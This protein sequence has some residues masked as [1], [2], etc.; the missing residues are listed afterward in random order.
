MSVKH[1]W[2]VLRL[3]INMNKIYLDFA[4]TTPVENRVLKEMNPY[5]AEKF[6][7]PNS[8]HSFGREAR[9]GVDLAREKIANH[10]NCLTTEIVFTSGATEANNLALKGAV[11]ATL[12]TLKNDQ[13]V[14]IIISN[15]EHHCILDTAEFLTKQGVEVIYA[16]V[17]KEG[18]LK[19]ETLEALINENTILVSVMYANNEIGTIQPIAEI[20]KIIK[21]VREKRK[22]SLPIYFHT[23][24]V[25]A[26]NYLDCDTEKLGVDLLSIS[27]HKIYGPK[28]VGALYK[29]SNVVILPQ[30]HGG[31]Q[32]KGLRSGTENVAGIVGFG[33]AVELVSQESEANKRIAE[34]RDYFLNNLLEKIP[35]IFLNGS[36]KERLP[37]NINITVLGVEGEAILLH[38]DEFGIAA[39]TGSACTSASLDPSHVILSLGLPAEAAHGSLRFSLGRTTTKKEIEFVLEKLPSII[40]KLR[41]LSPVKINKR[42]LK[43]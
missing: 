2:G 30:I 27:S 31:G 25:Q 35:N 22:N 23:D 8:L 28:G 4:A 15:I 24:A 34:L 16:P 43:K 42:L 32:E 3:K 9:M 14:N 10:L 29:K 20:S 41:K 13:K 33:K 19:L 5:F 18:L 26:V 7:N 1:V 37:N 11:Q 36:L 21:K 38:L 6:G 17:D 12:R 40:E 39:S